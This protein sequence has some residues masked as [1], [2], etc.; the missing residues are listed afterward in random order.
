MPALTHP[1][2]VNRCRPALRAC[3]SMDRMSNSPDL[4]LN[5]RPM[6]AVHSLSA[7][8]MPN[9]WLSRRDQL[10]TTKETIMT[11]FT[12]IAAAAAMAIGLGLMTPVNASPASLASSTALTNPA[13]GVVELANFRSHRG[14]RRHRGFRSHRNFRRFGGFRSSRFRTR[15]GFRSRGFRSRS[16]R[17]S[18]TFRSSRRFHNFDNGFGRGSKG[19]GGH[20]HGKH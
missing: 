15:R 16:F 1:D 9:F 14:F 2:L 12:K 18:R 17:G 7:V 13:T 4:R 8:I 10:A 20:G 6:N 19:H 5:H 3:N 11:I